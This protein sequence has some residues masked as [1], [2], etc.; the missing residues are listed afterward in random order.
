MCSLFSG[1]RSV[2]VLDLS[3]CQEEV[4]L[5]EGEWLSGSAITA[6]PFDF[7]SALLKYTTLQPVI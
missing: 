1:G 5:G 6:G 4:Q 7:T 2:M 3:V